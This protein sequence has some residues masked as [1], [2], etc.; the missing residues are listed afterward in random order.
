LVDV[1]EEYLCNKQNGDK[2]WEF[3][4]YQEIKTFIQQKD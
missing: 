3:M 1:A 2:I 4:C